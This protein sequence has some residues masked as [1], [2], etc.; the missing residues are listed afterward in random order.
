MKDHTANQIIKNLKDIKE[1]EREIAHDTEKIEELNE[2]IVCRQKAVSSASKRVIQML[3]GDLSAEQFSRILQEIFCEEEFE[4]TDIRMKATSVASGTNGV[5]KLIYMLENVE[6]LSKQFE[7]NPAV[8][9]TVVNDMVRNTDG[10]PYYGPLND[11]ISKLLKRIEAI[12]SAR[13]EQVAFL[14]IDDNGTSIS[15]SK[16]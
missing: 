6:W 12:F 9:E 3:P 11:E 1:N 5:H 2:D 7:F 4:K 8:V 13:N 16:M 15:I 10:I 14:N